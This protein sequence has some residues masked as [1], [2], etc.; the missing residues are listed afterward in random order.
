MQVFLF[1]LVEQHK[2]ANYI[3]V[4]VNIYSPES[5]HKTKKKMIHLVWVQNFYC[6]ACTISNALYSN[7]LE[8]ASVS[9]QLQIFL[10][11]RVSTLRSTRHLL[12]P[13]CQVKQFPSS[14]AS[15][16]SYGACS[17]T[18]FRWPLISF[19]SHSRSSSIQP[20]SSRECL[21][22]TF[23]RPTRGRNGPRRNRQPRLCVA[24]RSSACLRGHSGGSSGRD[25]HNGDWVG[26]QS[27]GS[28]QGWWVRMLVFTWCH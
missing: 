28:C 23:R 26:N 4:R 10:Y 6:K 16:F 18:E 7:C 3:T 9:E 27:T 14:F 19:N 13:F 20:R 5:S 2:L 25:N 21:S 8:R 22:R 24:L 17:V 15:L 12:W 1:Q 11:H